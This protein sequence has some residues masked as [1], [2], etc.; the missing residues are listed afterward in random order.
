MG[1]FCSSPKLL[2]AEHISRN[3]SGAHSEKN[4]IN[5][6]CSVVL[7]C[8][9][10]NT[11]MTYCD[12]TYTICLDCIKIN[13]IYKLTC[14]SCWRTY[15]LKSFLYKFYNKQEK[16]WQ[17]DHHDCNKFLK[18]EWVGR[19]YWIDMGDAYGE[20]FT[21]CSLCFERKCY[22]CETHGLGSP[23]CWQ[24]D[25]YYKPQRIC[26]YC[27]HNHK[28]GKECDHEI[29]TS[30]TI[31]NPNYYIQNGFLREINSSSNVNLTTRC[32]CLN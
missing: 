27:H 26:N 11:S 5:N 31:N 6:H 32:G 29:K 8:G 7:R 12:A 18:T 1:L 30:G 24:C 3:H 4:C 20:Q 13:K 15:G 21:R 25:A 22:K 19:K 23:S 28:S 2:T 9:V 17:Y 14:R 10:N 16:Q